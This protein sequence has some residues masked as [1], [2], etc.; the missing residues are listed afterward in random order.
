MQQHHYQF[1]A[2]EDQNPENLYHS[3]QFHHSKS[4]ILSLQARA[5]Q[6]H[7]SVYQGLYMVV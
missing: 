4:L 5:D 6:L 2:R 3:L 1:S 7:K